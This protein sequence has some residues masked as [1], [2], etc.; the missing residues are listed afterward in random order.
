[1]AR[2]NKLTI[3]SYRRVVQVCAL[4]AI[5]IGVYSRFSGLGVWPL[6]TD[7]YFIVRSVDNI[8]QH[9]IPEFNCGGYYMRG[10]TL[11]YLI[12]SLLALGT[13]PEFAA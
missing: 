3:A 8:L 13:Q 11:Q 12:A 6:T 2:R 4:A 10:L 1:M 5:A 9:G 7:E